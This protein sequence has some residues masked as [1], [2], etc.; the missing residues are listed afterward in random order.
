MTETIGFIG[1]GAMGAPMAENL[2]KAGHSLCV[3]DQVPARLERLAVAG[4]LP[5]A[6]SRS[7][8]KA[9]RTVITMLPDA[10]H[11][12]AA[13]LGEDGVRAGA[14]EGTLLIDMSTIDPAT[15]RQVGA[16]L[17]ES[18]VRMIDAPV[19]RGVKAATEGTLAIFVGGAAEDVEA[20]RPLLSVMGTDVTHVG[21]LGCGETV[22]LVN[23]LILSVT[24][25]ALAEGLVLGVKGGVDPDLLVEVLEQGSAD[26]FALRNHVKNWV[27]KGRF[28]EGVFPVDYILKDLRRIL[29]TGRDLSVPLQITALTDQIYKAARA[30]G[31]EKN[32]FPVIIQTLER[33]AGVTVRG[34]P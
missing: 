11:V 31:F 21:D 1:L 15:T 16:A 20:A 24:V 10:P 29:D 28:D 22:K 2:L 7:V 30:E 5:A 32:Y 12:T 17:A 14:A 23:Q 9:A 33:L 13:V 26:S 6:S 4:A 8:A 19:A 34:R 18:G 27:M 3:Y 25:A